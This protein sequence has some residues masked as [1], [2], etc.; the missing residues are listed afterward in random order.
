MDG[1]LVVGAVV[2]LSIAASVLM[3]VVFRTLPDTLIFAAI[4]FPLP[5]RKLIMFLMMLNARSPHHTKRSSQGKV[6][7][8][9]GTNNEGNS[10]ILQFM[11][12]SVTDEQ[13]TV[14]S[15][16]DQPGISSTV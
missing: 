7:L 13:S 10:I 3:L 2:D 16:R 15:P 5:R 11:D 12:V 6:R 9:M 14:E 8:L 4:A 1:A